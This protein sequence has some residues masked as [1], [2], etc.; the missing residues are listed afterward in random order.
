MP[1]VSIDTFFA[2]SLMILLV[3][4][5]MTATSTF[6]NPQINNN[7]SNGLSEKYKEISKLF[8][9]NYGEPST[10]G[11]N[12]QTAP[13]DF[14]LAREDSDVPY[15]LGIDKVSRLN[16]ENVYALRYDEIFTVAD[17]PDVSFRIEVKPVF[18]VTI[19]LTATH[20]EVN[21]T[22]YQLEVL[23]QK[24]GLSV[25]TEL[26]CY[27]VAENYLEMVY[28]GYSSGNVRFNV[29][30]SDS[31]NGP[32]LL[33]ALAKSDSNAKVASFN[34]YAFAHNSAEPEPRGT[35]LRL[36]PLNHTLDAAFSSSNT[37]LSTAYA[38]TFNYNSTLTE[39]ERSSESTAFSIPS[40]LDGPMIIVVSGWNSTV[41]FNEWTAYPQVPLQVGADFTSSTPTSGVFAYTNTVTINCAI[42]ECTIWLGGPRR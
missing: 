19:N 28:D 8:L 38:L 24:S 27:L 18:D 9:L 30:L 3:L 40:L 21:A 26:N 32:A 13:E 15:E 35:F 22:V 14:G 11:Q 25:R 4:S 10:W 6:L 39:I 12:G 41:F 16:S 2:C 36:S 34:A 1:T 20:N 23:T 37:S 5:A 17:V 33:V 31:I 7:V 42:Y 29:S